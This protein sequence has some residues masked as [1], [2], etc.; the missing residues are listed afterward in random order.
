MLRYIEDRI[1]KS[2][3][4]LIRVQKEREV[5]SGDRVTTLKTYLKSRKQRISQNCYRY[6]SIKSGSSEYP[7]ED[8]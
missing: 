6:Q 8:K 1:R 3:I 2:G 7:R 5:G 4:C